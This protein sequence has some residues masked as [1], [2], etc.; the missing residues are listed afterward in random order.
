[1]AK[2]HGSAGSGPG[3]EKQQGGKGD[4]REIKHGR[5]HQLMLVD[6]V[7]DDPI[8]LG[9]FREHF[10][11]SHDGA[12]PIRC[13]RH[14]AVADDPSERKR[15]NGFVEDNAKHVGESEQAKGELSGPL[16]DEIEM[17]P[18]VAKN[19]NQ[20]HQHP[21]KDFEADD[22]QL[23]NDRDLFHDVGPDR[24]GERGK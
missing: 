4:K 3:E 2:S 15:R 23:D 14:R 6:V 8:H 5:T 17:N 12:G 9:I 22:D 11:A 18:S 10:D 16:R 7:L 21:G 24:G 19:G 13:L 20:K 1:M